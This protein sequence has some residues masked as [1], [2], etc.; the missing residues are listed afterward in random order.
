[1]PE[2]APSRLPLEGLRVID[3]STVVAGP[4]CARHLAD[5]GADVIKIERPGGDGARSLGWPTREGED[6][7]WWKVLGRNKRCLEL[8]LSSEDGRRRFLDL[9][10]DAHVVVE[11]LRAGSMEKLGLGPDVL[12]AD[13]PKL[14]ITRV[15]GFGLDGPYARRP[16]FA[17]LAEAMS[18]FA[19]ANGEPDGP[20]LPPPIALA[21][22][23]TG[24][25]AAFATMVA[26]W[27]G[28]GQVVDANLLESMLQLMGPLPSMAA[29]FG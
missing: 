20:P 6:S 23:T 5:F 10:R 19:A 8:D 15:S 21:D 12:W 17:T 26:L 3:C 9:S 22:E 11:N 1:M 2:P 24:L 18:G 27:S 14:V 16:G 7:I 4:G 13:N 25:V 28:V 29:M